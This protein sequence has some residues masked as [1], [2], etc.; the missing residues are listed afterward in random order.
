M[1]DLLPLSTDHAFAGGPVYRRPRHFLSALRATRSF[2]QARVIAAVWRQFLKNG[3]VG[4]EVRLG[5]KARSI[6]LASPDKVVIGDHTVVR[7][8]LRNEAHG[9]LEIG[10]WVYIGDEV[11]ISS[12]NRIVIG[13]GTL[14]AHGVQIFDN[15]THPK[16]MD[17]RAR[18]F[19]LILGL[20]EMGPVNI[21]A[22]P[23]TIGPSCWIGMN[24]MVMKGVTI[25]TGTIVAAGSV[26]AT[27]LPAF[28]VAT[29]NPAR[30]VGKSNTR[31][32]NEQLV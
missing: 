28:A 5:A 7:G 22:R 10:A 8:I 17:E 24:A 31:G 15:D 2:G 9:S 23:V 29:G 30:V 1:I 27:D 13:E 14:I 11:V 3:L 32:V 26:V 20:K 18:H 12:G 19:R 25:G 21:S 6:N 4:R 16:D